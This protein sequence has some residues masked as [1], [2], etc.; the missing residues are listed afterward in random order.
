MMNE[1][2]LA[3][4]GAAFRVLPDF[5]KVNVMKTE[6]SHVFDATA[7]NFSR[8]VLE[9]SA[10]G[11]VLVHYWTPRAGPC[12]MLMPRLVNLAT[13]YG[14]RFLLVMLNTDD[15][16]PLARSH[17]VMSVPT[18]KI[19]RDGQVVDTLHG[20]ESE[21]ALR[22][23]I[24]KHLANSLEDSLRGVLAAAQSGDVEHATR[25]AAETAIAHP[26]DPRP[27]LVLAQLLVQQR[28]YAQADELLRA[29]PDDVRA[30]PELTTLAA[31]VGF[32]RA[33]NE[34]P[35]AGQLEDILSADPDNLAARYQLGALHL[36]AN[37]FEGAFQQLMEIVRRNNGREGESARRGLLALFE[38]LGDADERVQKRRA[39]L[40][41]I[42]PP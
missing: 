18:L 5:A 35:P 37:D 34:A 19:F 3:G 20:A 2:G 36:V 38:M 26:Q 16:G 8:L 24:G 23:F 21:D 22:R 30:T 14:G 11:P 6:T 9:N 15:F 33:A 29:L 32:M 1:P 12:L 31:H 27:P 39:Q 25:L 41:E 17:G 10:K 42:A 28:Q 13:E 40:N 7:D 4:K